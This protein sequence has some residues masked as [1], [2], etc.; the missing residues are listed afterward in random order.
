LSPSRIA[1]DAGDPVLNASVLWW[2]ATTAPLTDEWWN[3]PFFYPGLGVTTFTEHLLGVSLLASPIY[4]LTHNPLTTYN[5]ALFLTWPL[6]A[7]A[8]YL[9]VSF[10][11]RRDDAAVL[12]GLAW[13]FTPYRLSELGHLQSLSAYWA[14]IMLLGLHGFLERRRLPWLVLFGAAW[15][16]QSLANGYYML[17]GAVLIG[18]WLAYFCSSRD[19]WRAMPAILVT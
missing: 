8:V 3:A 1:G 7:F 9:L 13:A 5:L 6:S 4:W 18:M 17:F 19:G 12:A 11:T 10:L 16:G 2:N 15:L 14:P